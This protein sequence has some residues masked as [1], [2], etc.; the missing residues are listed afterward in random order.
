VL[1]DL[2]DLAVVF[3]E[4]A[5]DLAPDMKRLREVYV[6]ESEAEFQR[7]GFS[8]E[9]DYG[10]E[11]ERYEACMR[12]CDLLRDGAYR[13]CVSG[14]PQR[15]GSLTIDRFRCMLDARDVEGYLEVLIALGADAPVAKLRRA[16]L[17]VARLL[18]N[19][20]PMHCEGD[21]YPSYERAY[22]EYET[23]GDRA[24][25]QRVARKRAQEL[26]ND[27]CEDWTSWTDYDESPPEVR[28]D[29]PSCNLEAIDAAEAWLAKAGAKPDAA[30]RRHL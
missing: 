8:L 12:R 27:A 2:E 13:R 5:S 29:P 9:R 18:E 28:S 17:A 21:S 26:L 7:E 24:A 14:T 23:L 22:T 16:R 11:E 19:P 1:R 25:M 20:G 4:H 15:C 6:A 10:A 30:W 3:P